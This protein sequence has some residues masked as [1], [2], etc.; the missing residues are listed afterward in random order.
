M[1]QGFWYVRSSFSGVFVGYIGVTTML[2]AGP[3]RDGV[4]RGWVSDDR[5]RNPM[6][7]RGQEF[8]I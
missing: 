4:A 8:D 3:K 5:G 2:A 6:A 7:A 1:H